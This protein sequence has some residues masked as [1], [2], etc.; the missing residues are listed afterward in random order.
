MVNSSG[1][2]NRGKETIKPPTTKELKD[3]SEQ[4]RKG[5]S[6]GGRTLADESVA[7]QRRYEPGAIE[8]TDA[9]RAEL[10]RTAGTPRRC[11]SPFRAMVI[12]SND[13]SYR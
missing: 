4:L 13:A 12:A 7:A 5:H 2:G 6:S 1:S 8:L 11:R 3:A 9:A 10:T